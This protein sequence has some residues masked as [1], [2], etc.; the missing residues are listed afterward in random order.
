V[1]FGRLSA[2]LLVVRHAGNACCDECGAAVAVREPESA[3]T[4]SN[5]SAALAYLV[6]FISGV[7]VLMIERYKQN[8]FVR[9]HAFQSIFLN[10]FGIVVMIG[11]G[12]IARMLGSGS[13]WS[14]IALVKS[15]LGLAFF[16][17][18][19]LFMTYKA[20]KGVRLALPFMG[21]L[22]SNRAG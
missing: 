1:V 11:L 19:P 7:I 14:L 13:L 15:L 16:M 3:D 6:G 21:P 17:L 5:V 18:V 12:S 8:P 22:A 10:V 20:F 9:F 4:G 2:F